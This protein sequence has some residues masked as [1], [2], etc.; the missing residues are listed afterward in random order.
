MCHKTI[1]TISNPTMKN[2]R[3]WQ[4]THTSDCRSGERCALCASPKIG[5]AYAVYCSDG[6]GEGEEHEL[7]EDCAITVIPPQIFVYLWRLPNEPHSGKSLC[8]INECGPGGAQVAQQVGSFV[9]IQ[10][11]GNSYCQLMICTSF[12]IRIKEQMGG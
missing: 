11:D 6:T 7:C 2:V 8:L 4:I 1:N 9:V 3:Y 12:L 5:V 10:S